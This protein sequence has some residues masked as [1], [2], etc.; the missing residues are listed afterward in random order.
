MTGKRDEQKRAT[1]AR[2]LDAATTLLIERGYAAL[3]TLAVQRTAGVTRGALLHHFPTL[4][5][6]LRALVAH[7]VERNE[8]VVRAVALR[9]DHPGDPIA[10]TLT[11]LYEAMTGPAA[12]A[13][14]EL[15]AAA[16]GDSALAAL[17]RAAE[18]RAG[19]DLYRVIDDLFGPDIVTHPRYPQVRDLTV[20]VLR[21][22]AA[23]RPLR[24]SARAEATTLRYWAD[25]I[26]ALLVYPVENSRRE[27]LEVVADVRAPQEVAV[28]TRGGAGVDLSADLGGSVVHPETEI[29]EPRNDFRAGSL[30]LPAEV[31]E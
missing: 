24:D 20:A 28:D 7:L 5:E 21:G 8:A 26:A 29:L 1:R 15:W 12:T 25:A 30:G 13:E 6:L 14:F 9:G 19:R 16:R 4:D 18:R 11:A 27:S 3:S 10:R 2:I 17:L 23:A 31:V 22:T